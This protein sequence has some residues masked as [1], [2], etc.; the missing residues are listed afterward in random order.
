MPLYCEAIKTSQFTLSQ[1][2]LLLGVEGPSLSLW[3]FYLNSVNNGDEIDFFLRNFISYSRSVI[4]EKM[5]VTG[6][7]AVVNGK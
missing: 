5:K 1:H 4:S 7:N 3:F 2:E 6:K